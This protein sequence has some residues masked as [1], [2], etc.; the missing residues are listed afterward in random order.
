V[1][2]IDVYSVGEGEELSN[3]KI[4]ELEVGGHLRIP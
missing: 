2:P 3:P 4:E 1:Q